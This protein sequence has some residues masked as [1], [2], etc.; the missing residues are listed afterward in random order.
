MRTLLLCCSIALVA[1]AGCA[2]SCPAP[3][4]LAKSSAHDPRSVYRLDFVVS[5]G[6]VDGRGASSKYSITVEEHQSGALHEGANI[7]ISPQG[8]RTDVGVKLRAS[9]AVMGEGVL[10][11][12]DLEMS[13]FDAGQMRK[14]SGQGEALVAP[15]RPTLVTSIED[16]TGHKRLEVTVTAT[17]LL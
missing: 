1:A 13:A 15:G 8:A 7:Q 11:R 6:D 16:A 5:P 14:L 3:P 9:F 10:V 17:K 2:H 12:S 4:T